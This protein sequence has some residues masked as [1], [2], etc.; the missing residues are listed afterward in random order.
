MSLKA[1]H[2]LGRTPIEFSKISFLSKI[3]K[4]KLRK[5]I[6][7][8]ECESFLLTYLAKWWESKELNWRKSWCRWWQMSHEKQAFAYVYGT[9]LGLFLHPNLPWSMAYLCCK[10]SGSNSLIHVVLK[11]VLDWITFF[12]SWQQRDVKP[13]WQGKRRNML[14]LKT[15]CTMWLVAE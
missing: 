7:L 4:P 8:W 11:M 10:C 6:I 15:M 5:K 12:R 2:S 13:K 9:L 3:V 14:R 1:S